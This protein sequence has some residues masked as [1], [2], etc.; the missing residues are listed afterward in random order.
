MAGLSRIFM[1]SNKQTNKNNWQIITKA[2]KKTINDLQ[3]GSG[4][5]GFEKVDEHI[6]FLSH[7]FTVTQSGTNFLKTNHPD[8]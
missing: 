6:L 2:I 7:T 4:L 3:P 8:T 1:M 5:S